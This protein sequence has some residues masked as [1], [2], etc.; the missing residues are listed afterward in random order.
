MF[1]AFF[2]DFCIGGKYQNRTR[3]RVI[4]RFLSNNNFRTL[5]LHWVNGLENH[6]PNDRMISCSNGCLIKATDFTASE[7]CEGTF[8]DDFVNC[9]PKYFSRWRGCCFLNGKLSQTFREYPL[10]AIVASFHFKFIK[11]ATGK[12]TLIFIERKY[13]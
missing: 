11:S 10:D 9:C 4:Q 13:E 6:L 7:I 12:D 1:L 2:S 5:V 3:M 8:L